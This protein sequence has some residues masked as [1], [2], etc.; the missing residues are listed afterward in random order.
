MKE[1]D[2]E[3][4]NYVQVKYNFNINLKKPQTSCKRKSNIHRKEKEVALSIVLIAT[5]YPLKFN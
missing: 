5:P 4:I 3:L 1:T 2:K